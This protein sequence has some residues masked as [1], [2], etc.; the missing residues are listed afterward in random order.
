MGGSPTA[1]ENYRKHQEKLPAQKVGY[2]VGGE[3]LAAP[4]ETSQPAK[5]GTANAYSREASKPASFTSESEQ[6]IEEG[7]K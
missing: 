2:G 7:L 5:T 4:A 6:A 3:M 1:M